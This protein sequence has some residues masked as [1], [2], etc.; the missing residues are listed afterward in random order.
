MLPQR[1]PQLPVNQVQ[2]TRKRK[3]SATP[4]ITKGSR[5]EFRELYNCELI[6]HQQKLNRFL[7]EIHLWVTCLVRSNASSFISL[8]ILPDCLIACSSQ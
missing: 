1:C 6:A 7:V 2:R 4:T 3:T 5:T 8:S